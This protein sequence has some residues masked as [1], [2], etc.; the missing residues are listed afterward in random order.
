MPWSVG[1]P[2]GLLVALCGAILYY[3]SKKFKKLAGYLIGGGIIFAI[4]TVLG[5]FLFLV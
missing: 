4:L 1:V 5:V 2:I 3:A